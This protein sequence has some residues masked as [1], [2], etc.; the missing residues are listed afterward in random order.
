MA[1]RF[2]S[3]SLGNVIHVWFPPPASGDGGQQVQMRWFCRVILCSVVCDLDPGFDVSFHTPNLSFSIT[4]TVCYLR[5]PVCWRVHGKPARGWFLE[6]P[7]KPNKTH[8]RLR[9][10]INTFV[11]EYRRGQKVCARPDFSTLLGSDVCICLPCTTFKCASERR[12]ADKVRQ[13]HILLA[14]C[15][16]VRGWV[17]L[18]NFLPQ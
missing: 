18:Q 3:I 7:A 5:L 2:D 17:T 15:M 11:D 14:G 4:E 12:W 6:M 16:K 9:L 13:G 8:Q 10:K 1:S